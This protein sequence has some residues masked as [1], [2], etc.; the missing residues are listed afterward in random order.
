MPEGTFNYAA[1]RSRAQME[2]VMWNLPLGQR[3]LLQEHARD[4]DKMKEDA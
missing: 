3:Q 4:K 2:E 1:K